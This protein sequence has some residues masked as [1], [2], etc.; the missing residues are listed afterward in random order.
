MNPL[1][2][3]LSSQTDVPELD[4]DFP[5]PCCGCDEFRSR[6]ILWPELIESWQLSAYETDY[7]DQQQGCACTRCGVNLRGCAL[8]LA[9]TQSFGFNG[10]L[11]AFTATE[12]A[13]EL[14]VLEVNLAGKLTQFLRKFEGHQL[15]EYPDI[16]MQSMAFDDDSLDLVVHSDTLE[17]VPD[18]VR[19]LTECARVLRPGGFCTFT[20]PI[21]VDRL[22]RNREGLAPSHHGSPTGGEDQLVITEY[23]MDIWKHVVFAG[24][25]E[26][27]IVPLTYPAALAVVG[28]K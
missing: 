22:T 25:R 23:G 2:R 12:S 9:I 17:H 3:L 24:F 16:D 21:V 10:T 8:A 26:C 7:I 18:P 4:L 5:C 1:S 11:E 28:V 27:R 6:R 20:V 15:V 19:G 13:N 14:R